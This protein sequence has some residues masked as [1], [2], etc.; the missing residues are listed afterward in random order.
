MMMDGWLKQ[1]GCRATTDH[2]GRGTKAIT[3]IYAELGIH[4]Q[5]RRKLGS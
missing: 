3:M 1:S 5:R 4:I 2:Y